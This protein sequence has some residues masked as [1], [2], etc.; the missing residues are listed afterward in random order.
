LEIQIEPTPADHP[1]QLQNPS[2]GKPFR[3]GDCCG[4]ILNTLDGRLFFPGDTR[5]MEEHLCQRDICFLALDVS[6][7]PYHLGHTAAIR[8]ANI[9]QDALLVPLHYGTYDAP[10]KE[11]HL[12]DPADVFVHVVNAEQRVHILAPGE[13]LRISNA[14]KL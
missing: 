9:Y 5:L 13:V 14:A 7:C 6:I 8:L 12:G 1:W 11:A 10:D 3:Q 2:R 4:F